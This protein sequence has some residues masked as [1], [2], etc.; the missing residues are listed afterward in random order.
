MRTARSV[1]SVLA[2]LLITASVIQIPAQAQGR[3]LHINNAIYG[4]NGRGMNV[5]NKLR[6]MVQNNTLNI[7]VNNSNMG[8]DPNVGADKYL[9]VKYTYQGRSMSKVVKEGD[10]LQLP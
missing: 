3:M 9:A 2:V 10:R 4:K 7:K 6:S 8:G 5:T 1:F